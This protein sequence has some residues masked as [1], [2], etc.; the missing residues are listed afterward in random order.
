MKIGES[1]SL[2]SIILRVNS[3]KSEVKLGFIELKGVKNELFRFWKKN[4]LIF[5]RWERI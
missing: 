3:R 5:D 2:G 1:E 4:I